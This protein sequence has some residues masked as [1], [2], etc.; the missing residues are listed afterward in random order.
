MRKDAFGIY[1]ILSLTLSFG[2]MIITAFWGT[3][4]SA[5]EAPMAPSTNFV[6]SLPVADDT[7]LISD[8]IYGRGMGR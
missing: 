8:L 1:R 2:V 7:N 3:G 5:P 4:C 6:M